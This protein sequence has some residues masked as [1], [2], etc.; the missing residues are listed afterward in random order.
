V[1]RN[2][3]WT[4]GFSGFLS[5][6]LFLALAAD[7]RSTPWLADPGASTG[8]APVAPAIEAAGRPAAPACQPVEKTFA[9]F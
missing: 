2:P 7:T 3:A 5:V 6:D 8:V 9:L 1:R 4:A